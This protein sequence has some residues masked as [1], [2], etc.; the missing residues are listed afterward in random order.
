MATNKQE[1]KS[2]KTLL[3]F[4]DSVEQAKEQSEILGKQTMEKIK[5]LV[6]Q[7][8]NDLPEIFD[9]MDEQAYHAF[10]ANLVRQNYAFGVLASSGTHTDESVIALTIFMIAIDRLASEMEERGYA[11]WK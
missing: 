9:K 11:Q 6:E 3:E 10:I 4:V 5:T 7:A 8:R 2:E 1:S